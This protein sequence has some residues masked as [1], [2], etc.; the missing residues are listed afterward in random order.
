MSGVD[1]KWWQNSGAL[2]NSW[3]FPQRELTP[4]RLLTR[5]SEL[6]YA[7]TPY[8]AS[9]LETL[10]I[11]ISLIYFFSI[12]LVIQINAY[13]QFVSNDSDHTSNFSDHN[14]DSYGHCDHTSDFSDHIYNFSGRC[15]GGIRESEKFTSLFPWFWYLVGGAVSRHAGPLKFWRPVLLTL[16]IWWI[17]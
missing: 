2:L 7:K 16:Q 15:I 14:S 5:S 1:R 13:S 11:P 4:R 17:F 3:I 6:C 8:I 12:S 9:R 10:A